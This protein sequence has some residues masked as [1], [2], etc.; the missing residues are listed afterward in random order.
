MEWYWWLLIVAAVIAIGYLKI[1]VWNK[2]KEN[3]RKKA[4]K[5]RTRKSK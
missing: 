1:K 5:K 3:R 4:E 2:I